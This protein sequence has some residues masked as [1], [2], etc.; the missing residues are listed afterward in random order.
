MIEGAAEEYVRIHSRIPEVAAD[1]LIAAGVCSWQIWRDGDRLFHVIETSDSYAETIAR[2]RSWPPPD[3]AWAALI[4]A[5]LS[6]DPADDV[7]LTPVWRLGA[8]GQSIE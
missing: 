4:A 5:L 6:S 1:S 3:V 8:H 2:L 7:V